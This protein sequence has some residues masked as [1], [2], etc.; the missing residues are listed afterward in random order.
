MVA[1]DGKE[2]E[3]WTYQ[4]GN[5]IVSGADGQLWV[6]TREAQGDRIGLHANGA[7]RAGY[8]GDIP[9]RSEAKPSEAPIAPLVA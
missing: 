7:W 1:V 5:H 2:G 9:A 4:G 6:H 8:V 3:R